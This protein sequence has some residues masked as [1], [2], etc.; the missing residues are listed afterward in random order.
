MQINDNLISKL[1][2]FR[3]SVIESGGIDIKMPVYLIPS[4]HECLDFS[5]SNKG[6]FKRHNND[7][8]LCKEGEENT[9][10]FCVLECNIC[11]NKFYLMNTGV[12]NWDVFPSKCK[13][14]S[15]Y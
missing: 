8:W 9:A 12:P 3:Q 7:F 2:T 6:Y 13:Q 14:K 11:H 10:D 1:R 4:T 5:F 15:K